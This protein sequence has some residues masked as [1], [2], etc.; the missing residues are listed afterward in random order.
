ML[1]TYLNLAC[2]V[3]REA[4]TAARGTPRNLE[5][6]SLGFAPVGAPSETAFG[7]ACRVTMAVV[8]D[9]T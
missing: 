1:S 5:C 2:N 8:S 9:E 4:V 6:G 7:G 3:K